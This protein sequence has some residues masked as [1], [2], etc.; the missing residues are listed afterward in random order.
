GEARE[1]DIG[2]AGGK[3]IGILFKQGKVVKKFKEHELFKTL[4]KEINKLTL[5]LM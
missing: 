2:I 1:A 5:I 3:G 4:M